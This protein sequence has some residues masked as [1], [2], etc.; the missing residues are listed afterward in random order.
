MS[1]TAPAA[2]TWE[3]S[4]APET[5]PVQIRT[6]HGL[7]IG[8]RFRSPRSGRFFDTINPATEAVLGRVAEAGDDDVPF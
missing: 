5:T 7:F 8:G 4:P 1:T 6:E 3:Y 2:P